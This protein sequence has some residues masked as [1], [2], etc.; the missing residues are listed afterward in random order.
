MHNRD[1]EVLLRSSQRPETML[2][3]TIAEWSAFLEGVTS[4]DFD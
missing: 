4:G 2:R 1:G 3:L